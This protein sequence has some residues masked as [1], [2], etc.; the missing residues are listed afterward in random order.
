MNAEEMLILLDDLVLEVTGKPL[1]PLEKEILRLSG[2][3]YEYDNMEIPKNGRENENYSQEYIKKYAAPKLWKLLSRITGE[4]VTKSELKIVLEKLRERLRNQPNGIKSPQRQDW[5]NAPDVSLFYDR[6]KD[7]TTLEKW[8]LEDRCRLIA[9]RGPNGI[10]KTTLSVKLAQN[11]Q[12]NFE[13]VIWRSLRDTPPV[14]KI[15]F[16][17]LDFFCE[18]EEPFLPDTLAERMTLLLEYLQ[19]HRCLIVLDEVEA[20]LEPGK[21]SGKYQEKHRDY[22]RL[23]Q[24]IAKSNHLSCLLLTTAEELIKISLLANDNSP[25]RD[26]QLQGLEKAAAKALLKNLGLIEETELNSLINRYDGNPLY[27]EIVGAMIREI[28]SGKASEY[29]KKET[30]YLGEIKELLDPIFE[31]MTSLEI[32]VIYQIAIYNTPLNLEKLQQRINAPISTSQFLE[33][34]KSL[35]SRCLLEK[36]SAENEPGLFTISKVVRKYIYNRFNSN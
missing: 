7:L 9:L 29:L 31:R 13:Y 17:L 14:E 12:D 28:F 34:L 5:G 32:D 2:E 27:L 35:K 8:I 1:K 10:G 25:V 24:D 26:Y 23:F 4:S 6:D 21:L 3:G 16:D 18:D 22:G 11:L 20:I 19:S 36:T 33:A 30:I 15:V